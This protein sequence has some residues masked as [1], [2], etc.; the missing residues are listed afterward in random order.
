MTENVS[1]CVCVCQNW[2]VFDEIWQIESAVCGCTCVY[3]HCVTSLRGEVDNWMFLCSIFTRSCKILLCWRGNRVCCRADAGVVRLGG[4]NVALILCCWQKT[5]RIKNK[6]RVWSCMH[7][8]KGIRS[9]H[10]T[11][12]SLYNLWHHWLWSPRGPQWAPQSVNGNWECF[13]TKRIFNSCG[14]SSAPWGD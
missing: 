6:F 1:K 13:K 9:H 5:L 14:I 12:T 4:I 10:Q 7:W 11:L 2:L 3:R 8:F